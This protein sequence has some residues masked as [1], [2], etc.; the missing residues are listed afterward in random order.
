MQPFRFCALAFLLLLVGTAGCAGEDGANEDSA[1]APEDAPASAAR[2]PAV[3]TRAD[4]VAMRLYDALGGPEVWQQLPYLRFNFAVDRG[5]GAPPQVVARHLW[6]RSSGAYR[7]EWSPRGD[8][9]RY[10]ALFNAAEAAD[11]LSGEVY[12]SG[13]AV[14]AALRDTLLQEA[15]T[16][17][18]NDTYWLLAPVKLFD[19]GVN[20]AYAADSSTAET[21]VLRVSFG[22]VGLTP[23]DRYWFYV[24][25]ETGRLRRWAFV[26]EGSEPGS[27]PR[28]F[29]WTEY[30][31]MDT[32]AG[33]AVVATRKA[34]AAGPAA[35]LT[36]AVA[37]PAEVADSLFQTPQP[38]LTT[39]G[40]EQ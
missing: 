16:R 22:G 26:L 28:A 9:A 24:D 6:D 18:I 36:D 4:S 25:K 5:Q 21:D 17:Y 14:G 2:V 34:S 12:R 40:D 39:T 19:P 32:P 33:R 31:E 23:G 8:T 11:S 30:R 35:I 15:Y 38:V 13:A 29:D 37:M 7:L 3:E 10:V 27:A 1:G 20:L